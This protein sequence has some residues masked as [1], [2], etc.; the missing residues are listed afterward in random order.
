M[1]AELIAWTENLLKDAKATKKRAHARTANQG[2]V[3]PQSR[4]SGEEALARLLA[5]AR[6]KPAGE[7]PF[8][9]HSSVRASGASTSIEPTDEIDISA[10]KIHK[11]E[12]RV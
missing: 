4:Q 10:F 12:H 2:V 9:K 1:R 8:A 3:Q 5:K 7:N 6:S 11:G